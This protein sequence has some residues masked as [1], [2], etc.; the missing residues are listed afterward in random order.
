ME[1][2][3]TVRMVD[4]GLVVFPKQ[5]L[6]ALPGGPKISNGNLPRLITIIGVY[7]SGK[8]PYSLP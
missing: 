6:E 8:S 4:N 7:R 3:A 2:I 5:V 1:I